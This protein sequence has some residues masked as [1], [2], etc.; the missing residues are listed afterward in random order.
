[1][2]PHENQPITENDLLRDFEKYKKLIQELD[3]LCRV[4]PVEAIG[5]PEEAN[6][7]SVPIFSFQIHAT[8]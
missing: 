1:M 4:P 3:S 7:V 8:K 2:E 6:Y 5:E